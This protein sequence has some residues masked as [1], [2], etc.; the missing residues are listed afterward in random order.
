MGCVNCFH[1]LACGFVHILGFCTM[2]VIVKSGSLDIRYCLQLIS[3]S[4]VPLQGCAVVSDHVSV[5]EGRSRLIAA[6]RKQLLTGST[7]I[8]LS[9]PVWM[10]VSTYPVKP[11]PPRV[12]P[13]QPPVLIV[14]C[15]I[16]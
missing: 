14:N 10:N 9:Q 6:V 15:A 7:Q 3:L 8:H 2:C 4:S 12:P 16:F 11:G 13:Q 1:R 5:E